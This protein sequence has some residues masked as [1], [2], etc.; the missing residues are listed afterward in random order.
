[1][2]PRLVR[3]RHSEAT[4]AYLAWA[5]AVIALYPASRWFAGVTAS[6]R[7]APRASDRMFPMTRTSSIASLLLVTGCAS[8]APAPTMSKDPLVLRA[9]AEVTAERLH[10]DLQTLVG[11][12]TRHTRS[13][14]ASDIRGIGAARRWLQERLAETAAGPGVPMQVEMQRH[15]IPAGRRMPD[16]TELVNVVATIPGSDADRVIV[17]SGHYDSR[18]STDA[19]ITGDAP[20]AN[21]DGSGT[22]AVLEAA[23]AI[24]SALGDRV[25]R[26]TIRFACVAGE[27]QGLYGSRAMASADREAGR[28]VFAMLTND[29]VGGVG[30]GSGESNRGKLRLFSEGVASSDLAPRATGSDNDSVSRQLARYV[31][32]TAAAY[33][34]DLHVELVFRQDR[35]LRGGDHKAFNEQGYAGVRFTDMYEH[36]DRQHQDVRVEDG[37]PYGDLIEHVD[38]EV[39]ADVTRLNVATIVGLALAPPSPVNVRVDVG[40]L[41][42]DSRL[43]W[44]DAGDDGV[45]GYRI[46]LRPTSAPV[47][48]AVLDVG[49]VR[50]HTL[51]GVSKDDVLFAVEAYDAEGR[52]SLPVYPSPGP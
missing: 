26:A 20:G 35:Y 51:I 12:G 48:T 23:R 49:D 34:P 3:S 46:R 31:H 30:G 50:E 4:P 15:M 29:I 44:D 32:E 8:T 11:F 17:V 24:R 19:D 39:L 2:T 37:R 18:N 43:L 5:L 10:D 7:R 6:S 25:P 45:A 1:M 13:D 41:S 40:S 27:E 14:T 38:F 52:T 9:V 28:D 16:E 22:V 21:D 36:F 33:L 42:H 47:W